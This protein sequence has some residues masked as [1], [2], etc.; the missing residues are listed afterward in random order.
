VR[1]S[2]FTLVPVG[3]ALAG[4]VGHARAAW[5]SREG[6]WLTLRDDEGNAGTGECSPLPGYSAASLAACRAALSGLDLAA[7]CAA[8]DALSFP[9]SRPDA[10]DGIADIAAL[11]PPARFAVETALLDLGA[12][13][14]R[15]SISAWLGGPGLPVS[16]SGLLAVTD[17][18]A[19]AI[20]AAR[21]LE[22]RSIRTIKVKIGRPG[23]PFA[24]EVAWL[25]GLRA[26]LAPDTRLR[27]DA[28]GAF[29]LAEAPD[30][31][32]ALARL[33]PELVEEPTGGSGLSRL[34]QC[35]TPWA[36]DESLADE[37]TA[38]AILDRGACSALVL[39]PANLG[40]LRCLSLAAEAHQRGLRV[41]VTHLFDGP[42]GLAAACELALALTTPPLPCGLDLH[43]ALLAY[44]PM[45][46]P[47]LREPGRIVPSGLPGHGIEPSDAD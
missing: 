43:E 29:S 18:L 23:V 35:A 14:A 42:L 20:A 17:D 41:L 19:A 32:A 13:R 22:A 36:A 5:S 1:I 10:L 8:A 9:G 21:A 45:D 26:A 46:I 40:L 2:S 25:A 4:Q 12:R 37:A 3:G 11:P 44:P 7:L 38:R 30:R 47:Q 15:T 16:R 31:L 39:K 24:Q 27:L 28:N 33:D 6:L 34:D